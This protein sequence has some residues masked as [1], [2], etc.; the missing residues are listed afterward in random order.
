MNL[1]CNLQECDDMGEVNDC[2]FNKAGN[3]LYTAGSDKT[4]H[5]HYYHGDKLS[6]KLVVFRVTS[7]I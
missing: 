3:L 6:P 4:I 1:M 7:H 5:V 2:I